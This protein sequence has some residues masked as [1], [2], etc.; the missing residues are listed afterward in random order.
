MMIRLANHSPHQF[1]GWKRVTVDSRPPHNA[2][3]IG[4]TTYVLGRQVGDGVYVLDVRCSLAPSQ[5]LTLDLDQS[6][7]SAFV[8]AAPLGIEWSGG[9]LTVNGAATSFVS[10]S[11]DGA[12][13]LAHLRVRS[14]RMF[15]T[16]IYLRHYPGEPWV[17]GELTNTCSHPAVPDLFADSP[18]VRLAFGDGLSIAAGREWHEAII[19]ADSYA[20]GQQRLVP[21]TT[22]FLRHMTPT[23]WASAQAVMSSAIG[24]VGIQR[25]YPQGNPVHR[26]G[27]SAIPWARSHMPGA[28]RAIH[29][30]GHTFAIAANSGQ[31][32]S[33]FDQLYRHG[34]AM[35]PD[36]AGA[37]IT[38]YLAAAKWANRP[39]HHLEPSGDPID[40]A[41]HPACIFW[42]SRPHWH[43]NVGPDKLG[44]VGALAQ[45]DVPGGWYGS[46]RQHWLIGGLIAGA[47]YTGSPALQ[48]LLRHQANAFLLGETVTPGLSTSSADAARSVY[49]ACEVALRLIDNLEDRAMAERIAER[50]RQRIALVYVPQLGP[51]PGDVW[52]PRA[53]QR[54]I[55][56]FD[57]GRPKQYTRG[58]MW[59]Q[60]AVGCY[61][62]DLASERMGNAEGRAIALR[63]AKAVIAH[64]WRKQPDGVWKLWDNTAY[65]DGTVLPESEYVE[66]RAVHST[67]WFRATWGV[68]G[69]ATILRHEPQ[70]TEAREI[71]EQV[72]VDGGSW[73]PPGVQ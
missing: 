71:W 27:A 22:I 8:L 35:L 26:P 1:N 25:L 55:G 72:T 13:W 70:H 41:A 57:I 14:G 30:W 53:D 64:A 15:C 60:Q 46:D 37:E 50:L 67:G 17:H 39:C 66:G 43:P 24:G 33:Q 19:D 10:V 5:Q 48:T 47:R 29:N 38:S 45:W 51:K 21:F 9:P 12:A 73:V 65:T 59:W 44:K 6:I 49:Y 4:D 58:V 20:D 62:L 2:G 34:E 68:L 31:T 63:A 52:D 23:S 42:T 28:L 54:I 18:H 56:D 61:G 16:D 7:E 69:I 32:G 40:P 11:P 3:R 36:G